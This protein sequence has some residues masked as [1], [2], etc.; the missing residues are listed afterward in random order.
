M[1]KKAGQKRCPRITTSLHPTHSLGNP[2]FKL[3]YL[4]EGKLSRFWLWSNAP[5]PP[6]AL[7]NYVQVSTYPKTV[8]RKE[9]TVE[10]K[11]SLPFLSL[12]LSH[13]IPPP[14]PMLFTNSLFFWITC[15]VS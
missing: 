9:L 6:T 12:L 4:L 13:H 10:I 3:S 1:F 2:A 5:V 14:S 15:G 8:Q 11:L 7:T